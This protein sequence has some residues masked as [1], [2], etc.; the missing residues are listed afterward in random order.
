ME[1]VP[2][3]TA[4]FGLY[5]IMFVLI[6]LDLREENSR[7]DQHAAEV[8]RAGHPLMQNDGSADCGKDGF[9][10][11]DDGGGGGFAVFLSEN[12]TGIRHAGGH[13]AAVEDREKG[14]LKA[15]E[16]DAFKQSA[17]DEIQ[18][19]GHGELRH[20]KTEGVDAGAE[21]VDPHDM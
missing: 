2:F 9:R 7:E 15:G 19:C 8:C 17:S 18:D 21:M 16:G 5:G 6:K 14:C 11:E 10:G 1:N 12:L 20:G 4:L 13:D 3:K